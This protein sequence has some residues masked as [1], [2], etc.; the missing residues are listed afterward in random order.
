MVVI[1]EEID[2]KMYMALFVDKINCPSPDHCTQLMDGCGP[3]V[4]T[5]SAVKISSSAMSVIWP[6]AESFV[7]MW[8]EAQPGETWQI[9]LSQGRDGDESQSRRR[10]FPKVY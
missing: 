8:N 4:G 2:T 1:N 3:G 6:T 10:S 7:Q 9:C 5:L